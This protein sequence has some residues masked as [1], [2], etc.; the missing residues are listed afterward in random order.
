M[1]NIEYIIIIILLLIEIGLSA[2]SL[3]SN[4]YKSEN[5]P[6]REPPVCGETE[7]PIDMDIEECTRL[8]N[9]DIQKCNSRS[10]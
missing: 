3:Y 9:A 8:I 5:Y 7:C 6:V 4:S 10:S 2:T 1:K